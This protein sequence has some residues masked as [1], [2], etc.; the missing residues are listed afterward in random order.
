MIERHRRELLRLGSGCELDLSWRISSRS[1]NRP[2]IAVNQAKLS[3]PLRSSS[4]EAEL[5]RPPPTAITCPQIRD[6]AACHQSLHHRQSL[7][8]FVSISPSPARCED[9]LPTEAQQLSPSLCV[10][11]AHT[12]IVTMAFSSPIMATIAEEKVYDSS[13]SSSTVCSGS[14]RDGPSPSRPGSLLPDVVKESRR[15]RSLY[16]SGYRDI[17]G[18]RHSIQGPG[19]PP[20]VG[21]RLTPREYASPR[22]T[23]QNPLLTAVFQSGHTHRPAS[24]GL[25]NGVG[26]IP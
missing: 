13:S 23:D 21:P 17:P 2:F 14:P 25:G 10:T 7:H 4:R 1:G 11:D 12:I 18:T 19:I 3:Y 26:P 24:R 6:S 16:E 20:A 5:P 22:P 9:P 8:R 15:V